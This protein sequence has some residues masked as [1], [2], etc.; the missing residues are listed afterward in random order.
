[1]IVYLC[2]HMKVY[3]RMR[4]RESRS[5]S[6]LSSKSLMSVLHSVGVLF[7]LCRY[8]ELESV[9]NVIEN[10]LLVAVAHHGWK[11]KEEGGWRGSMKREHEEGGV[12]GSGIG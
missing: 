3:K 4:C 7:D 10:Y 1:M 2:L 11:E 6:P 12:T 5:G 9:D 8:R